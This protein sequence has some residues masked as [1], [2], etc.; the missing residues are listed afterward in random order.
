MT[1]YKEDK[2]DVVLMLK[3]GDDPRQDALVMQLL[4]V[5]NMLW[6]QEGLEMEM[7]LYDCISTG[8]EKPAAGSDKCHYGGLHPSRGDRQ[9]EEDRGRP[10]T[11]VPSSA[12]C[13]AMKALTSPSSAR[14]SRSRR[15]MRLEVWMR[16]RRM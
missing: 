1:M 6:E 3:V 7:M 13:S 10:S 14:G 11:L 2:E 12:S 4:G 9:E 8:H 16:R 5:M 15:G